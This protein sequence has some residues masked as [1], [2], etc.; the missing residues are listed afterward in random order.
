MKLQEQISRIQ[1]IIGLIVEETQGKEEFLNK[2]ITQYPESENFI[3]FI[4][5]FI[6]NSQCKKIDVARFRHPAMGLA[7][8]DGIVFNKIIFEQEL[9]TF[10]FIIFHELAHQYQ[11]KKYGNEKMYEFYLGDISVKEAAKTMKNIEIIADELASR[12]I[13]ELIKLGFL[14]KQTTF[15]F[16]KNYPL[17]HFEGLISQIKLQI[18][19]KNITD[20][21]GVSNLFYN[22]VKLESEI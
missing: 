10:L 18:K 15:G 12:K 14:K 20:F 8:H 6:N 5:S 17:S 3:D 7:L 9:S 11:F 13:R 16:Y 4:D 1:E 2:I 21:E 19:S 22:M